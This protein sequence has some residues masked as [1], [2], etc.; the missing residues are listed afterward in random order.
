VSAVRRRAALALLLACAATLVGCSPPD[1]VNS[2]VLLRDGKPTVVVH[3]C[4]GRD[5]LTGLS[6]V[7]NGAEPSG[8]AGG[9]WHVGAS[10]A[11]QYS[12]IRLF[13]TP[14]GWTVYTVPANLLSELRE[15]RSYRVSVDYTGP[16]E[17]RDSGV[18]FTVADLRSLGAGEVW[19]R[20][21]PYDREVPMTLEAFRRSAKASC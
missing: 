19:S 8:S 16:S 13:D 17:G 18:T 12:E 6:L 9:G 10:D 11:P 14:P 7:E 4:S 2:A 15:G 3:L 20:P 21:E 1:R 5:R